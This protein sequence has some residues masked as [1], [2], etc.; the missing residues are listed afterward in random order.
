M[1]L[2]LSK[3]SLVLLPEEWE[4]ILSQRDEFQLLLVWEAV[5]FLDCSA[6]G[7][8]DDWQNGVVRVVHV[9]WL[10]PSI[11][12][13][14]IFFSIS[15]FWGP[16]KALSRSATAPSTIFRRNLG[17]FIFSKVNDYAKHIKNGCRLI[18]L[19]SII[20]F[21]KTF[22]FTKATF[23]WIRLSLCWII[24]WFVNILT[25]IWLL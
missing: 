22:Q 11:A 17:L 3:L 14:N 8:W 10:N 9:T 20:H 15:F 24:S 1:S 21:P 13:S 4:L 18:V 16:Y 2:L 23:L 19:N 12:E 6:D 5:V 7:G 25:R